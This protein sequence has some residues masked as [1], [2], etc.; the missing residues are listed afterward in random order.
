MPNHVRPLKSFISHISG[1][2]P[3]FAPCNFGRPLE[4]S[5]Y[6]PIREAFTRDA[7]MFT[8]LIYGCCTS[9]ELQQLDGKD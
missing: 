3:I 7:A 2:L 4:D 6:A 1:K 5:P 8:L 9:A